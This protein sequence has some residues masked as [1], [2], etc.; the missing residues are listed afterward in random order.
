MPYSGK[1]EDL[2]NFLLEVK[3]YLWGNKSLYPND[4][5][6]IL[7]VISYMSDGDANAWKEEYFEAAKQ[8]AAQ[9][10]SPDPTLGTYEQFIKKLTNNFSPYD[11]PKD[12][13]H[14]MKEMQMNNT[15]IEE[16]VAKFKMLV[17]KSK[18][19]KNDAVIEY[20][21]DTLPYALQEQIGNLPTQ[22]T[23]LEDWY[24]WSIRLQ[25]N[26]IH[27]R[28]AIAKS[29]AKQFPQRAHNTLNTRR[30]PPPAPQWFYFELVFK[31]PVRSGLLPFLVRT[32]TTTGSPFSQTVK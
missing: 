2:W 30:P 6:K 31:G 21:R 18:L 5:D 3:I 12:A 23:N 1:H 27:T 10:N 8:A 9:T 11:A 17:T 25:N 24:T 22:P 20:F 28:S 32:E 4:E 7:F 13:I 19:E 15:P 14:D 26:Y 29:K 16:H